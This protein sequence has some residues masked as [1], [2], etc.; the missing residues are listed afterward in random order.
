MIDYKGDEEEEGQDAAKEAPKTQKSAFSNMK[1]R[2]Y[3][4]TYFSSSRE[5]PKKEEAAAKPAVET[6]APAVKAFE[7]PSSS[8]KLFNLQD[9]KVLEVL[10]R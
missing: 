6:K 4:R 1:I 2:P 5:E 7:Q 3:K 9:N 8:S 10:T